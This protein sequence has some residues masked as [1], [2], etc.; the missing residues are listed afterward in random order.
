VTANVKKYSFDVEFE[1]E[2]GAR[3]Y[4]ARQRYSQEQLDAARAEALAVGKAD[5]D[6]AAQ[7]ATAAALQACAAQIA[8]LNRRLDAALA[9]V[10]ADAAALAL[11]MARAA[12]ET[13]LSRF[14]EAAFVEAFDRALESLADAPRLVV[15]APAASLETLKPALAEVAD[16]HGFAGALIVRPAPP[17]APGDA[18]LAWGDGA[19]RRDLSALFARYEA[20]VSEAL[21]AGA[22]EGETP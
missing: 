19:V 9:E 1:P 20:A 14:G 11:S 6:A 17:G 15:S 13:A 5:A 22:H 3:T 2:N 18:A 21:A 8:A 4:G 16:A 10:R 7:Q 12:A